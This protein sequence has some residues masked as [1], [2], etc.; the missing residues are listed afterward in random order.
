LAKAGVTVRPLS[1]HFV[2]DITDQGLFLGFAAWNEREIDAG[3]EII[4]RVIRKLP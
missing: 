2:G 3:A 4:G 1:R